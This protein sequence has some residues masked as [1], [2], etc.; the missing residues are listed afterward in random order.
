M[1]YKTIIVGA[2]VI[3]VAVGCGKIPEMKTSNDIVWLDQ[4][5]S[6][7]DSLRFHHTNQ[8]T[9]TL[10]IPYEWF[11]ALEQPGF[12]LLG[13]KGL[14]IE[15]GYLSRLGFIS[16]EVT[17]YNQAGLPVG[18]SVDY[19][20]TNPAISKQPFNAIGLTC[21]ACHTGQMRVN[22]T[23]VRYNG[24]PAVTNLIGLTT[25]LGL[26]LVETYLIESRFDRFSQRVLGV[27][28]TEKNKEL[29]KESLK[30][31]LRH[32]VSYVVSPELLKNAGKKS[33][34][35]A[36]FEEKS[37]VR[38]LETIKDIIEDE[39]DNK[40]TTEGFTRLDALNRIGNAVFATDTGNFNNTATIHAPVNYPQIWNTSWF[41]WVQYDASIMGPMIRN[42]GEAMGVGAY[43]N[44]NEN[45][46]ENFNSS[47]KLQELEWMESLLAG[48]EPPT[49]QKK[50]GGLQHPEW[51]EQLL[52]KIDKEKH[53][54][55][56]ILYAQLCQG[57][58]LPPMDSDSFWSDKYWTQANAEGLRFLDLPIVDLAYL[59]TDPQEAY[60]LRHRKVD[61]TGVGLDTSI[62]LEDK[63]W[64]ADSPVYYG[65]NKSDCRKTAVTDSDSASFAIA[66]GAAVQSVTDYWYKAHNTP[67]ATQNKMNGYRLNCL[68]APLA[69]KAR[70][71]NGIWAT[72]PFLHNGSVP[73]IFDLLSPVS[74]RPSEF[75]LG[76][77]EYDTNKMG[78][79]TTKGEGY[80]L[81]KTDITGNSNK[82]HEFSD[83]KGEGVIGRGLSE[84][85]R[86]Q[87]IEYLKDIRSVDWVTASAGDNKP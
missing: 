36:E 6:K 82:G 29:L 8:G 62:Y 1:N 28:N 41:L 75:Y 9:M 60:V 54:K 27:T 40:P 48:S 44:L 22:G 35:Y 14:I 87:L 57:C 42:S 5:W 51:D 33:N 24:G 3:G 81:L 15:N 66:L 7:E 80:F 2:I 4:G 78:Y 79:K 63:N 86:Y 13:A 46:P 72:A 65:A 26:S 18:F 85:E 20:V 71:L 11:A 39:V 55:G 53:A 37:F 61:T 67:Q 69:Y 19:D 32:L 56:A 59:G 52:G 30:H 16:G 77:L 68:R 23:S 49:E 31:N 73:T 45:S 84:E 76:D 50:F 47:L 70:P 43:V 58:H 10:P 74:Q 17:P 38:Y 25:V 21:A 34:Q 64:F 12:S 83:T